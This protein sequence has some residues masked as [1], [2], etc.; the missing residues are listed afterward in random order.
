[1]P[2]TLEAR[3]AFNFSVQPTNSAGI[4]GPSNAVS[5]TTPNTPP[6][7][8]ADTFSPLLSQ[9]HNSAGIPIPFALNVLSSGTRDEDPDDANAT[10]TVS[11]TA[12][13]LSP[14]YGSVAVN[15]AGN[16]YV[17]TAPAALAPTARTVV[18]QY[19]V[20]DEE[21][22]SSQP[23]T[24]TITVPA[25]APV[26]PAKE[27]V[28]NDDLFLISGGDTLTGADVK[29]N[30][31]SGPDDLDGALL[32]QITFSS[33]DISSGTLNFRVNGTFDYSPAPGFSGDATFSYQFDDGTSVAEAEVTIRVTNGNS[34]PIASPIQL[35]SVNEAR[36]AFTENLLNPA[37]VSDPDGDTL[38]V[39]NV[40]FAIT[41]RPAGTITAVDPATAV[42]VTG[43][44]ATITPT[45]FEELDANEFV[46][47]VISYDISDGTQTVS[48]T[49]RLT[50]NG[51]A[52]DLARVA[53][54]Y[55]DTLSSRYVSSAFGPH[56][57]GQSGGDGSCLAC[58]ATLA[59]INISVA[60][61]DQCLETPNVFTQYGLDLCLNRDANTPPLTDLLRRM[62]DAEAKYAPVLAPTETLQVSQSA[63]VG[64]A[65]GAPLTTS[66]T[67][68]DVFGASARI[69][70][71]LI[72][73]DNG[74]PSTTDPSGQFQISESGQISVA[75]GNLA[76]GS[77]TLIVLPVN[78]AG[79]RDSRAA[80]VAKPGFYRQV[81]GAENAV[82]IEVIGDAPTPVDDIVNAI[83]NMPSNVVVLANDGGTAE[84]IS[85]VTAPQNG[86]AV[87]NSDLSVTYTPNN[88]FVGAD[89]FTYNSRSAAGD[90]AR[91]AT[92]TISVISPEAVRAV[93]DSATAI[94]GETTLIDVLANDEN[95]RRSGPDAT[96][97]TITSRPD[98]E[99]EGRVTVDGQS[100]SFT[101]Q[102]GFTGSTSFMY[103][104]ANPTSSGALGSSAT[105]SLSVVAVGGEVI[106]AQITDPELLKV[107]RTFEQSCTIVRGYSSPDA[108]AQEFLDICTR[109]T[110]A[111]N[112]D[113]DLA[114][115]MRALRNE[116]HFAAVDA[117]ATVARGLGRVVDRR[118]SQIRDGG[119]RGFNTDGVSLTIG[120]HSLPSEL[121]TQA[122]RDLLGFGDDPTGNQKWGLFVA[123]DIAWAERDATSN[124]SGYDLEA[125]NLM[126]GYDRVLSDWQS[127]GVA[128]GY[129]ETTTDFG[130]GGSLS[131]EGYQ[132]TVYGVHKD[133]IRRD[134]T[135]EGYFS[136]GRMAFESDRRINFSNGGV[137]VDSIAN[138]EFD[139][140]YINIAPKLSYGRV[141]GDYNDPIGALRTATRV[142]WSASLDYLWMNL[143][144]YVETGGSSLALDVD[145]ESYQSMILA[146]GVDASRPIFIGADTRAE[147]YGGIE[148][149][150]ELLDK[151]RTVSS[152]FVAAGPDAP[153]FLV[154]EAGTYGLGAGIEIGTVISFGPRG[155]IDLNYGYDFAGGGLST[156]HLSLGYR[157]DVSRNGS[158]ALNVSRNFRSTGGGD[159]AAELS[160]KSR[161]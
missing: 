130:G 51:L 19:S 41:Q 122:L 25:A 72:N 39:Q 31:G 74:V 95:T 40:T 62:A 128:L 144:D 30:N 33:D 34:A 20:V 137:T 78:D 63:T 107:A 96:I 45:V 65:I 92:V 102:A 134:L 89:S 121:V 73:A 135:L 59:T 157:L 158:M 57:E 47:I 38:S 10:L 124:A 106:S 88:D 82:T 79:Q 21:A 87:V 37:S 32:S 50:V 112:N 23:V 58:H 48:N 139:G 16:G 110:I 66:S 56:F 13:S 64:T 138:A 118:L 142:T 152:A 117:T 61:V 75:N 125:T 147:I 81:A 111:A 93:N 101:P 85:I 3:R 42:S 11:P 68:F 161:F 9:V 12:P 5:I 22:A 159:A 80:R 94:E 109:L 49:L 113:E 24:V 70:S 150:G 140:T 2:A 119:A 153:R 43:S 35:I 149:R 154:N 83:R 6:I 120:G 69:H 15:A 8:F 29:L 114:Q 129:A 160:Y 143:D 71:Y 84:S 4:A 55:A 77:Y 54:A 148:I 133:F 28:A 155:H 36:A 116:E 100:I 151:D 44:T 14:S 156:Q 52:T 1:V 127:F 98:P 26:A 126:I 17:Y 27:F 136:V 146:F 53:G 141:L 60:T 76:A 131:S 99:T 103:L 46:D 108:Q 18:F 123:G 115:A 104:A 105:V 7:A 67:G 145:S 90:A 91:V 97:V 86:I 132:A